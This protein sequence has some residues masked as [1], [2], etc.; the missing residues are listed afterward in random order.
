[1][2]GIPLLAS[3]KISSFS[4]GLSAVAGGSC[5][6]REAVF[7][8]DSVRLADRALSLR[9]TSVDTA[10]FGRHRTIPARVGKILLKNRS[11]DK[12]MAQI[13]PSRD[14]QRSYRHRT[15]GRSAIP[16]NLKAAEQPLKLS[17]GDN[18][19]IAIGIHFQDGRPDFPPDRAY[20]I[21][22]NRAW[23]SDVR[24]DSHE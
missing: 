9:T 23:D 2:S 4:E 22:R 8:E 10:V 21:D 5:L 15:A 20:I 14:A 3:G 24:D 1:M 16:Q 12:S 7:G 13:T 18:V 11:G 6:V 19:N 17:I